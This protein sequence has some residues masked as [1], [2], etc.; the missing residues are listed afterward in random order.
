MP[1]TRIRPSQRQI[2]DF[3]SGR[4][5]EGG[6]AGSQPSG[7]RYQQQLAYCDA[8]QSRGTCVLGHS[9]CD[10]AWQPYDN[11]QGSSLC[12]DGRVLLAA[13][14]VSMY[15]CCCAK[16]RGFLA[17]TPSTSTVVGTF[18]FFLLRVRGHKGKG[19]SRLR[20]SPDSSSKPVCVQVTCTQS[21]PRC[22]EKGCPGRDMLVVPVPV[23][24][25]AASACSSPRKNTTLFYG[26]TQNVTGIYPRPH[27]HSFRRS[28]CRPP[29]GLPIGMTPSPSAPHAAHNARSKQLQRSAAVPVVVPKLG[30]RPGLLLGLPPHLR[31]G[32]RLRLGS[33]QGPR[34]SLEPRRSPT[35]AA[36]PGPPSLP[37]PRAS[38][39][40]KR[41][42]R[43]PP[44]WR[45]MT[46]SGSRCVRVCVNP[47]MF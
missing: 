34:R 13:V 24:P 22:P 23:F 12:L 36:F 20:R 42:A 31:P 9:I 15:Y 8:V 4:C 29:L 47:P 21:A 46:G 1:S 17:S 28:T 27:R 14:R 43:L 40:R 45:T 2:K 5:A 37:R 6:T 41:R 39:P 38:G 25:V 35:A 11:D 33:D 30:P 3:V 7:T 16:D 19:G 10:A 32:P 26:S 44:R 18:P